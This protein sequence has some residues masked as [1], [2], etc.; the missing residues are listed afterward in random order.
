MA[1]LFW[2]LVDG[3]GGRYF[4]GYK[5]LSKRLFTVSGMGSSRMFCTTSWRVD[6]SSGISANS[7][8]SSWLRNLGRSDFSLQTK[9][10]E[11]L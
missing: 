11:V 3:R 5:G 4:P 6:F 8:G 1:F 10:G 7:Q 2:S 9:Q